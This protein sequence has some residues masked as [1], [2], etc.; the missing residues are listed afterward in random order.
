VAKFAKFL[1]KGLIWKLLKFTTQFGHFPKDYPNQ[2]WS[3]TK[4]NQVLLTWRLSSLLPRFGWWWFGWP[5]IPC[6]HKNFEKIWN[7]I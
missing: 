4:V 5:S 7:R 3:V 2:N 1:G 6:L